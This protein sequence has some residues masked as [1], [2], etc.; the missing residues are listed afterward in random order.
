M[1]KI[2]HLS[3][4]ERQELLFNM[5][6]ETAKAFRRL[7]QEARYLLALSLSKMEG[8]VFEENRIDENETDEKED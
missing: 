7:D 1:L 8:M 4:K 5:S 2:D 3:K 6:P